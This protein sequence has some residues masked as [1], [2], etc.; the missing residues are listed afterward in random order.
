ML[1]LAAA[2]G[3][4]A[5]A[6]SSLGSAPATAWDTCHAPLKGKGHKTH[7][8]RSAMASAKHHWVHAADDKYDSKFADWYYSGDRSIS[9]SWDKPGRHFWCTATARPCARH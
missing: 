6:V 8:M 2:A 7:D 5:L 4:A 9:C 1:A 3:L